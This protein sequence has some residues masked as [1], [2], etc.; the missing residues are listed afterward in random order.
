MTQDTDSLEFVISACERLDVV[1]GYLC[2]A[3]SSCGMMKVA[4][5]VCHDVNYIVKE[6]TD[7]GLADTVSGLRPIWIAA[8]DLRGGENL[9]T[10]ED[11]DW[12]IEAVRSAR[13]QI[14]RLLA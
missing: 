3:R 5:A 8:S 1:E 13:R 7:L 6:A 10:V 11:L 9:Y 4:D 14:R 2:R 12:T